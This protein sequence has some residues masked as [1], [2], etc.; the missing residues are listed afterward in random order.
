M[1]AGRLRQDGNSFT[2]LGPARRAAALKGGSTSQKGKGKSK[3]SAVAPI[4]PTKGKGVDDPPTADQ[5]VPIEKGSHKG[6]G[7]VAVHGSS[8]SSSSVLPPGRADFPTVLP[9]KRANQ[10]AV[11]AAGAS[12]EG[13]S[14]MLAAF[15]KDILAA[16]SRT[17][18][19]ALWNTWCTFHSVWF[20]DDV[21]ALPLDADK[22][23]KTA[24]C[25]KEGSYKAYRMYLSKAKELHI[26]AGHEWS[27]LLEL[28]SKRAIRSV[29]RGL[30]SSRQ[31]LPFN[32]DKALDVLSQP[33][34]VRL[35]EG[36]PVG[37]ANLIVIGTYF[38]MREM[39]L[40]FAK[41]AHV[42]IDREDRKF[43]LLLPVSKKDPRASGCERSWHCLCKKRRRAS[44]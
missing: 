12:D 36:T 9:C 18:G 11:L 13:K 44:T 25:F 6:K 35:P 24:S 1:W 23:R 19:C 4:L 15:D 17:T 34:V 33:D 41:V 37:W 31:S 10:D 32:V 26:I 8:A 42:R 16:S 5:M 3:P 38:V 2:A 40:A 21:P 39:E 29:L 27:P 28:V 7:K 43:T 30:G 20:N 14:R 22:I